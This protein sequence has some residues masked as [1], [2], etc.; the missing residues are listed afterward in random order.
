MNAATSS[1]LLLETRGLDARYGDFQALF[2]I[3]FHIAAGEVVALIGANGAGKST[4]LRCLTGLL[5]V[6]AEMVRFDGQPVGGAAPYEMVRRGMAMVPEGRRLFTGMS[7]ED[8][9]RVAVDQNRER[10]AARAKDAWTIDR[11][12]GLFPIL[13]ERRRAPV[14]SL[15][16]G[17]QQMVA[18]GRSLLSQPRLLLC[19]ELSLGLAPTVI[20]EIYAALPS[21]AAAGTAIVLVEQDVSLAKRASNRLYCMLEGRV[22][23][24]GPSAD[25]AR[26]DIARAY[27]GAGHA[28]A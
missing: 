6:A 23:L 15:S 25:I 11:L 2:G 8:N 10:A 26:E 14:E 20:R 18:I 17:Q 24:T 19:D 7:V 3:D 28:V 21:I 5:R 1:A 12:H 27:F 13:K 9:L 22:T 16:G 4:L